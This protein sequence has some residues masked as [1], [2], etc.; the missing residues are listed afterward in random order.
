MDEDAVSRALT[1]RITSHKAQMAKGML[2]PES[3]DSA[4]NNGN[5]N[6]NNNNDNNGND[7]ERSRVPEVIL[8]KPVSRKKVRHVQ[9]QTQH[10]IMRPMYTQTE[11]G[12]ST[13][14]PQ[15]LDVKEF[16][17]QTSFTDSASGTTEIGTST[18]GES[19]VVLSFKSVNP[20]DS[21]VANLV[22][23]LTQSATDSASIAT[24]TA[25][26]TG[27]LSSSSFLLLPLPHRRLR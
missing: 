4:Y 27:S 9:I 19:I 2:P 22:A 26:D 7:Q 24:I 20:P 13:F 6:N 15:D 14:A 10:C 16:A 25:T 11:S 12:D 21:K 18:D 23:S 8:P 3:A 1:D 17:T 5:N